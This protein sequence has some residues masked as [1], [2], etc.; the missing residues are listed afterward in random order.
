LGKWNDRG[1]LVF[2]SRKDHQIKH[3]G[4]RIELGEIEVAAG[5]L[6]GI[7]T[8]CCIYDRA[9]DKIILYYVGEVSEKELVAL[10]RE[11]L[12]RYMMPNK[13]I[14][15]EAMPRTPNGKSDR[16]LLEKLLDSRKTEE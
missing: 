5:A 9:S 7:T 13:V 4:H 2:V 10:L 15:L 1:E 8:C 14:P 11:K 3:M 16:K 12:P 6:D